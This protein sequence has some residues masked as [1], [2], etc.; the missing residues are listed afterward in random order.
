MSKTY[1][2]Q[3]G[4]Y[5][6]DFHA[7]TT[8]S[9]DGLHTPDEFVSLAQ[10]QGLDFVS[11]TDHNEIGGWEQLTQSPDI[12]V[13]S[14][15]EV[16]LHE[17]HWNVF[18]IN[19]QTAW[20]ADL[21]AG[22][23]EV[24]GAQANMALVAHT[25]KAISAR[26]QINSINHPHLPPWT[27]Q[28]G[29]ID[30]RHVHCL[31]IINDPTWPARQKHPANKQATQTA[32]S[33]WTKW[34]NAGHRIT[35]VG[36]TDYHGPK[37]TPPG[38]NPRITHPATYVYAPELSVAGILQGIRQRRAYVTMGGTATSTC[39]PGR[40]SAQAVFTANINGNTF[41]IGQDIGERVGQ[42]TFAGNINDFPA[43]STA[44][45]IKNGESVVQQTVAGAS[46]EIH[47][48][49]ELKSGQP[50]WYRLDVVAHDGEYLLIT[51]PI[52][53]GPPVS[54]TRFKYG[55]FVS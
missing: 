32:V 29:D 10:A 53:A 48:A 15:I 41:D 38:Y 14:G 51:N 49:D 52:F 36:G 25:M 5:R 37:A 19:G 9:S 45:I 23:D 35:A 18:P 46:D 27:W 33:M 3:P 54:P 34:L 17:G 30:L 47:F 40:R 55:D 42:I 2:N 50:V 6:G 26:G 1:N 24:A 21:Q 43:G 7:H 22:Y 11:I 4:W 31:E 8:V 20:M 44:H 12:L 16:T 28:F 39:D 13:M